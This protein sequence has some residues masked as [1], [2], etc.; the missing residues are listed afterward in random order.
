[1]LPSGALSCVQREHITPQRVKAEALELMLLGGDDVVPVTALDDEQIGDG[2]PG[3]VA[4]QLRAFILKQKSDADA[5]LT[6]SIPK[7]STVE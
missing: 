1:M 6:L 4:K 5:K 2:K 7:V 3:P